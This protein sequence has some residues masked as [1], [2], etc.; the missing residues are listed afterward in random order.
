MNDVIK[1]SRRMNCARI[2]GAMVL[3]LIIICACLAIALTGCSQSGAGEVSSSSAGAQSGASTNSSVS[4]ASSAASQPAQSSSAGKRTISE[5]DFVGSWEVTKTT[6]VGKDSDE[7]GEES[8]DDKGI[9]SQQFD[10]YRSRGLDCYVVLNQDGSAVYVVGHESNYGTWKIEDGLAERG[11]GEGVVARLE[12]PSGNS[13]TYLMFVDGAKLVVMD[14]YYVSECEKSE[15]KNPLPQEEYKAALD[16]F[17]GIWHVVSMQR[18]GV[19]ITKEAGQITTDITLEFKNDMTVTLVNGDKSADA[20]WGI[21]GADSAY[22]YNPVDGD[23]FTISD[24]LLTED[25]GENGTMTFA[26][27]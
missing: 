16:A 26:K 13:Y 24:G 21:T 15:A 27:E 8:A 6:Y 4:T 11:L 18:D 5:E 12:S 3:C 10:D 17:R 23:S 14:G 20:P 9:S 1:Q 22:V 7:S 2:Q 19:T 25:L